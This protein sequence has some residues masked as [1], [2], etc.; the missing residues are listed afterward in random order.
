MRRRL[1][2]IVFAVTAM[3]TVAFLLPLAAVVRVV[4]E[5]R[6]LSGADQE[7][8]SLAG[9]LAAVPSP[10]DAA[11]VVEQ[12][13][14]GSDPRAVVFLPDGNRLGPSVE[15]TA[16]ELAAARGGQAFST[17]SPDARRIFVPVRNADGTVTV[18]VVEVAERLLRRGVTR[19][20]TI[21][22]LVGALLVLVGVVLADRLAR[23]TVLSIEELG[24]VTNRLQR[25]ELDAR[26]HPNGPVEVVEVGQAVNELAE[27]IAEQ[28][29][30]EREAA[31]DLSHRLRTPLTALQLEADGLRSPRDR[32]RLGAA[33]QQLA[34]AVSEVIREAREPRRHQAAASSADL[35]AAVQARLAFWS[36]LAD[37][38]G[39]EWSC[40]LP[41][42]P[43]TV[44]VAPGDLSAAV[45]ALV[46]NVFAHTPEATGFRVLVAGTAG[47]GSTL[48]VEDDG[49]GMPPGPAPARGRSGGGSTGLGLDI[50]GRTAE[51][52]GG[53]LV[54]TRAAGG[55]ARLEVTFGAPP[56]G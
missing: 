32:R 49:A 22:G 33:V 35:G 36:V 16:G 45:D 13:N 26:V 15:V 8:R 1:A 21:L 38:Q 48:V 52:S 27:R 50:V 56:Q 43:T 24:R 25:G 39:R 54:I 10:R 23:S 28:L 40:T 17:S 12:L 19:A 44:A 7:V 9:V 2:L 34:E 30:N 37:D 29:A 42:G 55:G 51:R 46:S 31:A 3:V 11:A 4:A 41:D 18:A 5:D 20:W 14:A 47:R 53:R 6:A